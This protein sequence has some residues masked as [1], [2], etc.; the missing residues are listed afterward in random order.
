MRAHARWYDHAMRAKKLPLKRAGSST[1][2][3]SRLRRRVR[4]L[5][6]QFAERDAPSADALIALLSCAA[7]R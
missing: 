6:E 2:R 5:F 4:D 3:R 1:A 7:Y